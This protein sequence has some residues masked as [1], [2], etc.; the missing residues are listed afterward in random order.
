MVPFIFHA[1]QDVVGRSV[2]DT[3]DLLDLVGGQALADWPDNRDTAAY[4][5]FK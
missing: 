2:E 1:G 4:A 3:G 5:G